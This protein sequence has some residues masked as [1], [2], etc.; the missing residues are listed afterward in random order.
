MAV[1]QLMLIIWRCSTEIL[2][3]E[4]SSSVE[5]NSIQFDQELLLL[6]K[7]WTIEFKSLRNIIRHSESIQWITTSIP[8]VPL[9]LICVTNVVL[10]CLFRFD[11]CQFGITCIFWQLIL[12]CVL[13]PKKCSYGDAAFSLCT[14]EL[15]CEILFILVFIGIVTGSIRILFGF[16]WNRLLFS[17]LNRLHRGIHSTQIH[18][19]HVEGIDKTSAITV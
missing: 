2:L 18:W 9:P 6:S 4:F 3:H 12:F 7:A 17:D 8:Q 1:I 11:M 14:L 5:A 19:C 13:V 10:P 16:H 15:A